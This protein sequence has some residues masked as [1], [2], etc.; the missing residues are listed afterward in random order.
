MIGTVLQFPHTISQYYYFFYLHGFDSSINCFQE[1]KTWRTSQATHTFSGYDLSNLIVLCFV[2]ILSEH[3]F[4]GMRANAEAFSWANFK[5]DRWSANS[6]ITF[7]CFISKEQF[8]KSADK[9]NGVYT[10]LRKSCSWNSRPYSL[11][12]C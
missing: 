4:E 5:H 12:I 7:S 9:L 1:M 11:T 10:G 8:S 2:V 3:I 6:R